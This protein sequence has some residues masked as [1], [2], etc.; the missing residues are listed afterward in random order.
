M[1]VHVNINVVLPR[2]RSP[3]LARM[4][5]DCDEL[6]VFEWCMRVRA[7]GCGR[8][9]TMTREFAA[10]LVSLAGPHDRLNINQLLDDKEQIE[11]GEWYLVH[12][13]GRLRD[14][15][16]RGAVMCGYKDLFAALL[17][18]M[19]VA[20]CDGYLVLG[21]RVTPKMCRFAMIVRRLPMDLQQV[22]A[23]RVYGK[24]SMFVR[25]SDFDDAWA[26]IV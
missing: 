16:W 14:V 3:K 22:V 11:C 20:L 2:S 5:V 26:I 6:F 13:M 25:A 7:V 23:W 18:A 12:A 1:S 15:R 10:A 21:C 9:T 8:F 17:Y 24:S 4:I 19:I